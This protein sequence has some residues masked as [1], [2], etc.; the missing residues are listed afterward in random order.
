MFSKLL[1]LA[2]ASCL[3]A[4][5]MLA[6]GTTGAID[7][8]I[9]DSSGSV[10]PGATVT[11]FSQETGSEVKAQ[12]DQLGSCQFP[13][14]RPGHYRITAETAG[15]QKLQRDGVIVNA[16][17]RVRLNL[18]LAVG[19]V[20]ETIT[21]TTATPLL[22]S[23]QA[24]MGHVV[25][26]RTIGSIPLATRNFTQLLGTSAGVVGA[27]FNADQPGTGNDTVSVNGARRGSNNLLVDGAPTSNA[28]NNSSEGDGT[29]SIEFLSEFKVLTSLYGAEYGKNLGSVI[30]VTTR[31]G[32]N[33][34]HGS[35]YE[36]LRNTK[37][38]ARP[39][40]NPRRGQN[41]QNQFGANVGGPIRKSQ[42]FFFAGWESMRQRNANS[43]SATMM[44]VVPTMDQRQGN[45]G[46]INIIDP[47]TGQPF[48]NNRVPA[49]QLNATSLNIQKAFIPEP[50]FTS[51]GAVNFFASKTIPTNVNEFT[52]RIDHRFGDKDSIF[53]RFFRST[54]YNN[55]PF[56]QGYGFGQAT[57][58]K[59]NSSNVSYTHLFSPTLVLEA[60]FAYDQTNMFTTDED[61]TDMTT[62]GLKPLSV[63]RTDAGMGEINISDYVETFGN[64]QAWAD[65]V[66]TFTG[67][68]NFTWVK[69]QHNVKFGL[70][71]RHDLYNPMNTLDSRGRWWF[72]GDG[73]GDAYADFLMSLVRNKSFGAGAGELKMR[74][75][76]LAGYI[77]DEWKVSRNLTLTLGVRYEAY[78]QPAA[79]NLQMTNWYPDKYRGLGSTE[80]A[81][82][83]QGGVNGVPMS[84]LNN[85][86]NNF[87]PRAG[88]AWRVADNWVIRT[89]AGL[90]FDQR[91][92]QIAQQAFNNPPTFKSVAPDCAV[93]G[94]PCNYQKADNF[95]FLDP[96]YDPKEIPFPKAPGDALSWRAMERNIKTDNAWQYNFSV[97]RQLP[98]N[99]LTEAAYVGTKGTHLMANHN[100]NPLVPAGFDPKNPKA[101]TLVR[102]FAGFADLATNAQGGSS[103]YHSFQ[104]TGKRRVNTGTVQLAYTFAKTIGNGA[105]GARFFTS[106][107][108]TPWWDWSRARGLANYDRTQRV[109]LMFSQDLPSPV[110]TGFARHFLNNW[111]MNGMAIA[112]TG[113]PLTVTNRTSGQGLGGAATSSTAA[114]FS[115]VAAGAELVNSG[116]IRS[117]L[118][119]YINK[120]AW[121]K[122]PTGTV[123]NS[124]RG[125]FRGP[126]QANLDFSLFK[127][128][129]ISERFK[130][131]FRSEFFNILNHANFGN[132]GVN[133]DSGSFGQI[134]ST[135]VNA[136]LIQFALKLAF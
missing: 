100:A 4:L 106:M 112:Q 85:D 111:S 42:T 70:E 35:A 129:P 63:T 22:Q 135:S 18:R 34:I 126:G 36:F 37:L 5:P 88:I 107:F 51:G 61:T 62:L 21:I 72:T 50:N 28:L 93:A 48:P 77:S 92:G 124:G 81:G 84:T 66:K 39:F 82:I 20:S 25:E 97:Q 29:P 27:I 53:G 94:S 2:I 30:N 52:T 73:T 6:Q 56:E 114:L 117:K 121:S 127:R 49:S 110:K 13:V 46:S 9:S 47:S 12:T 83:V 98:W 80:A 10:I 58:T 101:G 122:A 119:N 41:V 43:G 33:D 131:E 102:Q 32:S 8:I 120:A 105:E 24:T 54:I 23:E 40:F 118:N 115:N 15:F 65:H 90:Y 108:I 11:A 78:W 3:A 26:Q 68:T 125:M 96:G 59:K 134:S 55:A 130:M 113:T 14:L 1:T 69:S 123:G 136:R 60:A 75:A 38:N 104:F 57:N 64:Y 133:L 45:F 103:S 31:S 71:S 76:T 89:G 116:D 16:T 67:T 17:E 7:I 109:S 19:V 86:M 99:V 44:A 128:I 132:P 95:T 74:D 87:M 79:Y 91:V